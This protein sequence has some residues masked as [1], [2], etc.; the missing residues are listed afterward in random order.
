[1]AV[2]GIGYL[3][4]RCLEIMITMIFGRGIEVIELDYPTW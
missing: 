3:G 2:R 1:M 4:A